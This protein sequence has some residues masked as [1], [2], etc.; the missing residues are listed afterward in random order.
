MS[1]ERR[2]QNLDGNRDFFSDAKF[3]ETE[4][5]TFFR[6]QIFRK[7]YQNPQKIGKSLKNQEFETKMSQSAY[8]NKYTETHIFVGTQKTY[9]SHK[10]LNS[11]GWRDRHL[12]SKVSC[13]QC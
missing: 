7:R 10:V 5:K 6:D 11:F 12:L 1:T 13:Y 8:V 9:Q 2:D 4:T 3:S